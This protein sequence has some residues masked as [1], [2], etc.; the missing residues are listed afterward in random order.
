MLVQIFTVMEGQKH[1]PNTSNLLIVLLC[2]YLFGLS[3]TMLAQTKTEKA[4]TAIELELR[5]QQVAWNNGNLIGFMAAY[6][7]SDSLKFVSKRGITY[8]W[9]NVYNNYQKSYASDSL[10]GKLDFDFKHIELINNNHAIVT[11]TWQVNN[12]KGISSGYF[13][14]WLKRFKNKWLIVYDH[15]S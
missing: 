7:P 3:Q 15:T 11:G 12:Q 2:I 6:L 5:K 14:L 13:T 1:V 10:M 4:K 8:G 9:Q